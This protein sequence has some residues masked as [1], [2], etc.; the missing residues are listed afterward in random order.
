MLGA[1]CWIIAGLTLPSPVLSYESLASDSVK[2]SARDAENHVRP[3]T[4]MERT[5]VHL[6]R[7]QTLEKVGQ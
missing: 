5:Q 7:V 6:H 2:A 3:T 4:E 1:G